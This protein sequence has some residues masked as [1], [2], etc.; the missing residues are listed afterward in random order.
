MHVIKICQQFE[1][2]FTT[3][4]VTCHAYMTRLH[5]YESDYGWHKGPERSSYNDRTVTYGGFAIRSQLGFRNFY[6]FNQSMLRVIHCSRA[7][8]IIE[9]TLRR[10]R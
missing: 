3:S 2:E 8:V 9:D 7:A 5:I 10:L 1:Y 6:L 4:P